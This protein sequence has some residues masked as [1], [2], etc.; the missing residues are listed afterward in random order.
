MTVATMISKAIAIRA[1]PISKMT[2]KHYKSKAHGQQGV[3][4]V[5][6]MVGMAIGL[7]VV[8]VATGALMV[9]RGISGTVSDASGIQQQAAYAMR[10]IGQQMRQAGSLYLNPA[11]VAGAVAADPLT[12]VAFETD[13]TISP[14]GISFSQDNTIKGDA[15]TGSITSTYRRYKDAVFA[16]ATPQSLARNCLGGP[17]DDGPTAST[18][19][20]IENIFQLVGTELQCGGN[21]TAA[22][23]IIQ[24]VGLFRVTYMEQTLAA[25]GSNIKPVTAAG[26]TNWRAVQGVEVCLVLYGSEP[27]DLPTGSNYTDCDGTTVVDMSNAASTDMNGTAIGAQRAKRMHMVFRNIFQLRS[28]GLI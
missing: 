4:L 17:A 8:A 19:E 14:P 2:M 20:A 23:A 21:G 3:T 26:V 22:Q 24:N 7:L 18:D 1:L 6:L 27:I 25:K 15:A 28:Q 9:S 5:E 12:A 11:P 16:A 13:A 10:V